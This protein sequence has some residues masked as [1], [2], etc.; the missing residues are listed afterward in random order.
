MTA[1][2]LYIL[3]NVPL[4]FPIRW[5]SYLLESSYQL[6]VTSAGL[7]ALHHVAVTLPTEDLQ[8]Q[9]ALLLETAK[10]AISG[11]DERVWSAAATTAIA[12]VL[13]VE[14]RSLLNVTATTRKSSKLQ[15]RPRD[16]IHQ[17]YSPLCWRPADCAQ[18]PI[19]GPPDMTT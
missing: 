17:S 3:S 7:W 11:A 5:H 14:G 19:L 6:F 8:W 12:L 15:P 1:T 13:A 18:V 4:C 2:L 16:T 9:R 10:R